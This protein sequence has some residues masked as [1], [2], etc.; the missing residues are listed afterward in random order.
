MFQSTTFKI[1]NLI[2]I[3][4][5]IFSLLTYLLKFQIKFPIT[6]SPLGVMLLTIVCITFNIIYIIL[7]KVLNKLK[8]HFYK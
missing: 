3:I 6:V 2:F 4:I 1:I 5:I 7:Y 8:I